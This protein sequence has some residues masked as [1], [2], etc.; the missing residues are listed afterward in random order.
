MKWSAATLA[1]TAAVALAWSGCARKADLASQTAVLEKTFPGLTKAVAAQPQTAGQPAPDEPKD[2]V[3]AAVCAASRN[4]FGSGVMLL[5]RAVRLPGL[6]AEQIMA[7][8][9]VRKAWMSDLSNRA[10]R[11]DESAKAALAAIAD[12][13]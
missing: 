1:A 13:K 6:S 11:G 3:L 4:D 8:S 10:A 9:D 12:A 2:C 7:V 5:H